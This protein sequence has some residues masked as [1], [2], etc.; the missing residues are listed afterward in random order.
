LDLGAAALSLG[1]VEDLATGT[2]MFVPQFLQRT[3]FPRAA[4]GTA[5]TLRHVRFGHMMRTVS[6]GVFGLGLPDVTG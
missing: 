4:E 6:L 5:S 3:V 2:R 1:V